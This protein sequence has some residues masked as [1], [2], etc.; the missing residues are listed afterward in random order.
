MVSQGPG[1]ISISISTDTPSSG[2][3]DSSGFSDYFPYLADTLVS[4]SLLIPSSNNNPLS[5]IRDNQEAEA[6]QGSQL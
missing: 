4:L 3:D 1:G 6:H 5:C 2:S